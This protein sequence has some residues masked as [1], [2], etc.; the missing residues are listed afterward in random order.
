MKCVNI[1]DTSDS[2]VS[3]DV[4]LTMVF[5]HVMNSIWIYKLSPNHIWTFLLQELYI[6]DSAGKE[7]LVDG[8]EKMVRVFHTQ[9]FFF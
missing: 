1:P 9:S 5:E 4:W 2:V 7:A 6:L 8:C 3:P